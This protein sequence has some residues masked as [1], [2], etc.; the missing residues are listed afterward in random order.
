[1]VF[2]WSYET[3]S[4]ILWPIGPIFALGFWVS[5]HTL[6]FEW[7]PKSLQKKSVDAPQ[8]RSMSI[9]GGCH[10]SMVSP[11]VADGCGYLWL[12]ILVNG[13]LMVSARLQKLKLQ[14]WMNTLVR[15]DLYFAR[16]RIVSCF[17]SVLF[18][19]MLFKEFQRR[20]IWDHRCCGTSITYISC[21]GVLPTTS[22]PKAASK[23]FHHQTQKASTQRPQIH[24]TSSSQD[25]AHL[26]ADVCLVL[27]PCCSTIHIRCNQKFTPIRCQ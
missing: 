18:Y 4:M 8:H 15:C 17:N 3:S 14:T 19:N 21:I 24:L 9:Q 23:C 6:R 11:L 25:I 10:V 20:I 26:K 12:S 2:I 16:N 22:P 5:L 7:H 27:G 1:M 13:W